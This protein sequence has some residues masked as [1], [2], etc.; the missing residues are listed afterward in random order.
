MLESVDPPEDEK[1]KDQ[2]HL[3]LR[4]SAG[5]RDE[6]LERLVALGATRVDDQRREDG[7]GW[8]VLQ[9]PEGSKFR[10]LRGQQEHTAT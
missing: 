7:G 4:P 1:V 10:I 8:V 6:E 2:L 5:T 9:D 3:D